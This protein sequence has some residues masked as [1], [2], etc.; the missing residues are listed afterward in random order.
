MHVKKLDLRLCTHYYNIE[1]IWGAHKCTPSSIAYI[2][3]ATKSPKEQYL[4]EIVGLN[5][6]LLFSDIL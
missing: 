5:T 6:S 1:G 4:L 3:I 2:Q